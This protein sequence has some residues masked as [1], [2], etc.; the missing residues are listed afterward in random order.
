MKISSES[1]P[2]ESKRHLSSSEGSLSKRNFIFKYLKKVYIFWLVRTLQNA[3]VD[4]FVR[5]VDFQRSV[6][7]AFKG[8]PFPHWK[9]MVVLRSSVSKYLFRERFRG[10]P[11]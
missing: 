3:S 6:R 9:R 5:V 4:G 2:G 11:G 7:K 8:N 10:V 1:V